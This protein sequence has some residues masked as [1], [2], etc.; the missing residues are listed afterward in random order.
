MAILGSGK[1]VTEEQDG[2][3]A[4]AAGVAAVLLLGVGLRRC[5][6]HSRSHWIGVKP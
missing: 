4:T 6:Y 3:A 2:S 1:I 5:A